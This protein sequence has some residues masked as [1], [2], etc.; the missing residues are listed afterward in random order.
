[1]VSFHSDNCIFLHSGLGKIILV[2]RKI[3]GPLQLLLLTDK[4]KCGEKRMSLESEDLGF[5]LWFHYLPAE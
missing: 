1:M 5:N 3:K 2:E 4:V